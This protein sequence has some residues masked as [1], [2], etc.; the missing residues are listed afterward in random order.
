MLLQEADH[1][2][3]DRFLIDE[4]QFDAVSI[5]EGHF[6]SVFHFLVGDVEG[7]VLVSFDV[8]DLVVVFF[9]DDVAKQVVEQLTVVFIQDHDGGEIDAFGIIICQVDVV[10]VFRYAF[11]SL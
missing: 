10:A 11:S 6:K 1:V 8:D 2:V 3:D 5:L 4:V 7:K 9:K